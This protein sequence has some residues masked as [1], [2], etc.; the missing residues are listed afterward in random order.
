MRD[1]AEILI[2]G[3]ITTRATRFLGAMA[4]GA[5]QGSVVTR[6][7][8]GRSRLL[9]LYGPGS[10]AKMPLI[11]EHVRRGGRVAMW[12]MAYWDRAESMRL[13]IDE[14]HPSVADMDAA[15]VDG[16]RDFELREEAEPEGHVVLVGLGPKS[17]YAYGLGLVNAWEQRKAE[18]LRRRF[19]G[20]RIVWRPKGGR[21]LPLGNLDMRH[22]EPFADLLRGASLVV[23]HHSNCSVDAATAGVPFETEQGAALWLQRREFTPANRLEFLRRLSWWEWGIGEASQAWAWIGRVTA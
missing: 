9:M 4:A 12:D 18:E 7:Y 17:V 3:T 19:P 6:F 23:S 2:D 16:R 20:R 14:L 11:R 21:P 8:A 10:P 22:E 1:R 5:P 15:P 13:S